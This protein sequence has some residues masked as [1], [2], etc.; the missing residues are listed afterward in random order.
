MTVWNGEYHR[1]RIRFR[2][3]HQI[4]RDRGTVHT[5]VSRAVNFRGTRRLTIERA[6]RGKWHVIDIGRRSLARRFM[7]EMELL[8]VL[9]IVEI[10]LD[11]HHVAIA[12][13]IM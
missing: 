11:G 7:V 4:E 9:G 13:K 2:K 8:A 1:V 12:E 10:E 3:N 5:I 6:S